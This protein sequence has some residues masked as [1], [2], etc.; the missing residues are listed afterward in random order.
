MAQAE[1]AQA[2]ASG[3][4]GL[5]PVAPLD[6]LEYPG[7]D[8][9]VA[10]HPNGSF[11]HGSAWARVLRETY[12]HQPA[13]FGVIVRGRMLGLLPVMEVK[14]MLKGRHGVALPFTDHCAVLGSETVAPPQLWQTCLRRGHTRG[15][16]SFECRGMAD[17]MDGA[18]PSQ[19]FYSHRLNLSQGAEQLWTHFKSRVRTPIRRAQEA[20]VKIEFESGAEAVKAYYSLHCQTRR[21][22]GLPPQPFSFFRNLHQFALAKDEGWI[23]LA[24]WQEKVV[25]AGV[26]VHLGRRAIHKFGASDP[27]CQHLCANHLLMWEAIRCY[28]G[29]GFESLELGRT[30][31]GNKGLRQFKLGFGTEEK[32]LHYCRFDYQADAFVVD[33]D[34]V[35]GWFNHVFRCLPMP[36]LR[37]AGRLLYPQIS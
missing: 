17:D 8:A 25:A 37:L 2:A 28:C 22:H 11:F 32:Q 12:G 10:A 20:G 9:L 19:S 14:S 6:P 21:K 15:W 26:F 30:S 18:R 36:L 16:R 7:W 35:E 13:Y 24:R 34:R 23:A 29:G 4:G 27:T 31:I 3:L 1:K 33:R 5:S